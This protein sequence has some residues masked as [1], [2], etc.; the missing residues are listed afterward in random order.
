VM[1]ITPSKRSAAQ[2]VIRDFACWNRQL[3]L[4]HAKLFGYFSKTYAELKTE[5]RFPKDMIWCRHWSDC[6]LWKLRFEVAET[7]GI[8]H[9]IS[10]FTI[11]TYF[12]E[13]GHRF[14][15]LIDSVVSLIKLHH[16]VVWWQMFYVIGNCSCNWIKLGTWIVVT[17]TFLR[18]LKKECR[19][20]GTRLKLF[21]WNLFAVI[22]ISLH[23]AWRTKRNK[24]T[25]NFLVTVGY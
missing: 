8:S 25:D 2:W 12:C 19:P 20:I 23:E 14:R 13:I 21:K 4:F 7:L 6:G 16:V 17:E 24:D 10:N 9:L 22:S 3:Y 18:K 15:P 5:K 1:L 11:S